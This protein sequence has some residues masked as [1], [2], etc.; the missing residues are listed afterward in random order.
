MCGLSS[1]RIASRLLRLEGIFASILVELL[2]PFPSI[3]GGAS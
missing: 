1:S 2:F 3:A